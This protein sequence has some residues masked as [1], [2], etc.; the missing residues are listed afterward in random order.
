MR[1][2]ALGAAL[3]LLSCQL[4]LPVAADS[5]E[6]P[7]SVRG[8]EGSPVC[9]IEPQRRQLGRVSMESVRGR[10]PLHTQFT[11]YN[12]GSATL[13]LTGVESSCKCLAVR[14][15]RK[16]IEPG[17]QAEIEVELDPGRRFGP[18][19]ASLIV[20]TNDPSRPTVRLTVTWYLVGTLSWTPESIELA[21]ATD[22]DWC[23][24]QANLLC[25]STRRLSD[26]DIIRFDYWPE[27]LDVQFKPAGCGGRQPVRTASPAGPACRAGQVPV[28]QPAAQKTGS[29]NRPT[30]PE[31]A[32]KKPSI[33]TRTCPGPEEWFT[34]YAPPGRMRRDP[35][36]AS[37]T[38]SQVLATVTVRARAQA[39]AQ[40]GTG[41][42]RPRLR[43]SFESPLLQVTWSSQATLVA[44][45]NSLFLGV[46]SPGQQVRRTVKVQH[47]GGRP[48]AIRSIDCSSDRLQVKVAGHASV[49]AVHTLIVTFRAAQRGRLYQEWFKVVG[50]TASPNWVLVRVSALVEGQ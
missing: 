28:R 49:Q 36:A 6:M 24:G 41:W 17:Q 3:G 48:F 14:L 35:T 12:D 23:I 45:P 5:S 7:A 27:F 2:V 34:S 10:Q 21:R 39:L 8:S 26:S 13:E 43:G 4:A 50:D 47:R 25:S 20:H 31:S 32:S 22:G 11:V 30:Q 42:V 9:R 37:A 1:E 18:N 16:R 44:E 40:S 33:G 46:L 38:S 15:R 19:S 29:Q